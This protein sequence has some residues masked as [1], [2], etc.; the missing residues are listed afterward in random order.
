[1]EK[2]QNKA[3]Y[4]WAAVISYIVGFIYI[5]YGIENTGFIKDFPFL[6][7]FI[8]AVV[9]VV[10][11]EFFANK[12][13]VTYSELKQR[14]NSW[15]EPII[16]AA[17]IFLQSIAYVAYGNHEDWGVYQFLMWHGTFV[18]YVLARTGTLA[19]GRSGILFLVD[20]FQGWITVP[21][22]N[23]FLRITTILNKGDM[24]DELYVNEAK[25]AKKTLNSRTI[26]TIA[27]SVIIAF[28]VCIY[29]ISQL[30]VA[31]ETFSAIGDGFFEWLDEFFR[32]NFWEYIGENFIMLIMSIPV[33][34]WLYGLVAASLKA[35]KPYLTMANFE[36]D[37]KNCHQLPAYSAYIVLGSLCFIYALFLGASICDFVNHKGLFAE[38]AHEAAVRA[39]DSFWSLI[40]VVLMNFA[41]VAGSCVF[42]KKALW[43]EK[44]TK[45]LVTILFLFAFGF[46]IM[47]ACNLCGVYVAIFGWTPR[48]ILSSWVVMNVIS[49]CVL[50]IIR[51]YKKIPAAQIGIIL[52]AVSFSVIDCFMF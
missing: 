10:C 6:G 40:R 46:A 21:L 17:C 26:A 19:A 4:K 34:C 45:I 42:S 35:R 28:F 30:A 25:E 11:T 50:L 18:Y 22:S 9:F 23:L 13:G 32:K 27:I 31:S 14:R 1:M 24:D 49:W 48:R 38:T 7:R 44:G 15:I 29:A 52:A 20:L 12:V 41:V 37:T 3:V 47:A 8:F 33:G 16:Y 39:I 5:K 2:V 51:F 43:E 36:E